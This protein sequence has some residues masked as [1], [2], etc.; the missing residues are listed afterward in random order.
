M[1]FRLREKNNSRCCHLIYFSSSLV[2]IYNRQH[3]GRKTELNWA[4][5]VAVY[6]YREPEKNN[7]NN[8]GIVSLASLIFPPGLWWRKN[9]TKSILIFPWWERDGLYGPGLNLFLFRFFPSLNIV[10]LLSCLTIV[11]CALLNIMRLLPCIL[12][13][14]RLRNGNRPPVRRILYTAG[15]SVGKKKRG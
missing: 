5:I 9:N 7:N 3:H 11:V 10:C 12:R 8:R 2:S 6:L 13:R 15:S 14:W 4:A 1:L